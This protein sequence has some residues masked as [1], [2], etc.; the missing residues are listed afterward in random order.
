MVEKTGVGAEIYSYA[1]D[2][3]PLYGIAAILV[4]VGAGWLAGVVFRN[5]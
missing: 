2:Q 3:A 5:V 1:H 4:A